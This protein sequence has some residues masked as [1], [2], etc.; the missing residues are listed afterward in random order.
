MGKKEETHK[1]KVDHKGYGLYH[2]YTNKWWDGTKHR[3]SGKRETD[4]T[5]DWRNTIVFKDFKSADRIH[6]WFFG[7]D[8]SDIYGIE[9]REIVITYCTCCCRT[10][11]DAKP[12][13][14][15]YPERY[16]KKAC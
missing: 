10:F 5:S 1:V 12:I 7:L 3:S 13:P 15:E 4:F 2:L 16:G 6:Q 14:K 11:Q 8:E 9:V